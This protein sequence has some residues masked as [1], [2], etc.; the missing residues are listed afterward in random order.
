MNLWITWG[1]ESVPLLCRILIR[2][3]EI[4]SVSDVWMEHTITLPKQLSQNIM[5]G[6][7]YNGVLNLFAIYANPPDN[8]D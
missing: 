5:G 7:D 3:C 8:D 6:A 1:V 2:I 4:I